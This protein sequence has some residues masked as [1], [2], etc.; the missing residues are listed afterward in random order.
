[1]QRVIPR[2]YSNFHGTKVSVFTKKASYHTPSSPVPPFMTSTYR[3]KIIAEIYY[4]LA[5]T[6][7]T[8][9]YSPG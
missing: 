7:N 1:M 3:S 9:M 8:I 6:V 4:I 2:R 5:S